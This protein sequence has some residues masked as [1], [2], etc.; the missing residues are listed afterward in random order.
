MA[1]EQARAKAVDK[2]ADIWAFGVVLYEMLTG[3]RLFEGETISDTLVAV[4]K[5][6][7]E[8]NRVPA[9]VRRLLRGCLEKEPKRRLRDVGDAWRLL[10]D[11]PVEAL[12]ATRV[13]WVIAGVATVLAI[14]ALWALWR[15]GGG[16]TERRAVR[17]DLDLGADV[18]LG[19][20]NGPAVVLSPNGTRLVFV[21]EGQ[22]GIDRLF[23]RGLDRA[24]AAQIPDTEGAYEP[25]FSPDGQW[26]GFFAQGKLKKTRI[27]GGEPVSLCDAPSGRGAS[28]GEDGNI[29]AALDPQAG[30]SLVPSGGGNA[31]PIT[32]P[33]PGEDSHRWPQILPG[34]K[35]VLFTVS[36][37]SINYDEAEIAVLSLKDRQRKTVLEHAGMYPRYL[38]SGHLVY[39]TKGTL[40]AVPF[41]LNRLEVAGAATRLE[42]VSTNTIRGF[43]QTDFSPSGIFVFRTGATE[44]LSTVHWLDSAGKT[45]SVGLDAA[46]FVYPRVSPDGRRLAYVVTEGS[47]ADLWIYDWQRSIKTRLTNGRVTWNPIW[48]PDGQFVAFGSAAGIFCAQADGAGKIQQLTQSKNRQ[49]PNSFGPDGKRLVFS[50]LISGAKGEIRI[51]P[52]EIG[53]GKV[54][55]GEPQSFVKT[56]SI[57]NLAAFCPDG[58]WL[59]YAN[60]EGGPYEV[61]V[62]AFPD[63]GT[64][65]QVSN[66]GGTMPA[67]SRN[68]HELFY[69]TEDQRIMVASYT[70]KGE[71]FIPD[72]PRVWF[73]KRLANVG[74]A[75]NLDVAPDGKRFI[76]LMP[77]EG[78]EPREAQSHLIL[79]TNFFDEVRRRVAGQVK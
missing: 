58:R 14:V 76:V 16:T 27:D 64:Q 32:E 23:T 36:T 2:R 11:V 44:G 39:V 51:L 48:S 52:V 42:E 19:S 46:R 13:P 20:S 79:L 3:R 34:G 63:R 21:S 22:D 55:S 67:W 12:H 57:L 33:S 56:S 69:R 60:A 31:V 41:D 17:L 37:A 6:E 15:G 49:A 65:V 28:W 45:E 72:K 71:S 18:S 8:W 24:K 73:G 59:A 7:P 38:P 75:V 62:R 5:E 29:I 54:R 10:E 77:A 47:G 78:P 35:I 25:F 43:A 66:A 74:L 40:L 1:P 9:K 61:Y 70:V 26:V 68:G 30:L 53:S 4:L 50:E